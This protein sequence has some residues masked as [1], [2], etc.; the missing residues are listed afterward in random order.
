MYLWNQVEYIILLTTPI[1]S[2]PLS[3]WKNS[4]LIPFKSLSGSGKIE[5][6][7][8]VMKLIIFFLSEQKLIKKHMNFCISGW[9]LNV[10]TSNN[11]FLDLGGHVFDCYW[12]LIHLPFTH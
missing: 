5:L 11:S 7:L 1:A 4:T 8:M 2:L 10:S 6:V 12:K 3:H 9:K